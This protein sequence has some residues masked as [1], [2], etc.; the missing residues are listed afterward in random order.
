MGRQLQ[1]T[2]ALTPEKNS[3]SHS[4]DDSVDPTAGRFS[5]LQNLAVLLHNNAGY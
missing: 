4:I 1:V 2:A 3:N 5:F